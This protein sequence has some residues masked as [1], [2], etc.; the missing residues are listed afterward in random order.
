VDA[1]R[2][3]PRSPCENQCGSEREERFFHKKV[4][5]APPK[6]QAGLFVNPKLSSDWLEFNEAST[7]IRTGDLLITNQLQ[8][9][10]SIT[11]VQILAAQEKF[12]SLP[13][14][15]VEEQRVSV[16]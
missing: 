1:K 9:S 7:R 2:I 16:L 5:V 12:A 6:R 14:G 3:G 10:Y 13:K 11:R 8:D 15:R 4:F